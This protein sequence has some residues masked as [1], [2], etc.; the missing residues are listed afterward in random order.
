VWKVLE[1][2]LEAL[3]HRKPVAAGQFDGRSH[4]VRKPQSCP[5]HVGSSRHQDSIIRLHALESAADPKEESVQMTLE[6]I[7][8]DQ[9]PSPGVH[10]I[11]F[12][13]LVGNP[14]FRP[15]PGKV[16]CA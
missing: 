5:C 12:M 13:L 3:D 16:A 7:Q 11:H 10:G 2:Y 9:K 15:D 4:P 1:R 8:E 14:L 6:L